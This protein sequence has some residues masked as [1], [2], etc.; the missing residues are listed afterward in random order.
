MNTNHTPLDS[1][2]A[3][4]AALR[5]L[6]THVTPSTATLN[7]IAALAAAAE[8]QPA[9]ASSTTT[10]RRWRNAAAL[11]LASAASVLAIYGLMNTAQTSFA[12]EDVVKAVR[13][14]GTVSYTTV[15]TP[16]NGP[17]SQ[18]KNYCKGTLTRTVFPDGSYSVMDMAGQRM[19]M[20][21]PGRKSATL[22]QLGNKAQ[23]VPSMGN[24]IISWLKTAETT[25]KPVGE[26]TIDGVRTLGFE[27]SF[28]AV[29]MTIWG[30]P[31]TKLPVQIDSQIGAPSEPIQTTMREFVFDAPLDDALFSTEPPA[32][33]E[34]REM[35]QPTIDLAAL[36]KLPPEEHVVRILKF[37]AGLNDGAFPE[38]IDGPELVSKLTSGAGAKRLEDPEFMKE[39]TTLAGSMG[40]TWTFRTTLDKFGYLGTAKLGDKDS[41]VFWYLPKDAKQFRVVYADLTTGDVAEDKLPAV[42]A[43]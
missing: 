29:T 41:I 14:T 11:L 15:I 27:A 30:D 10:A 13:Q 40:A 1:L 38:R 33:Y 31:K 7:R 18:I 3:A 20:V 26:K 4:E 42:P 28:G 9:T 35:K 25:G 6:P 21:Q 8:A 19:L 22:T 16:K 39:F 5:D 43:K 12:F 34:L 32:G 36:A 37:Y 2:D 17:A 24:S 23:D